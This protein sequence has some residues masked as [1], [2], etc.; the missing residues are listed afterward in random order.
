MKTICHKLL[1]VLLCIVN[2]IEN[3]FINI[4]LF[5]KFL[6]KQV[7]AY[8]KYKSFIDKL[9]HKFI[10]MIKNSE[11]GTIIK[12]NEFFGTYAPQLL[13]ESEYIGDST[14]IESNINEE[15]KYKDLMF[16]IGYGNLPPWYIFATNDIKFIT[17]MLNNVYYYGYRR[18]IKEIKKQKEIY[19]INNSFKNKKSRIACIFNKKNMFLLKHFVMLYNMYAFYSDKYTKESEDKGFVNI[20]KFK[21]FKADELELE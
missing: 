15:T 1:I 3:I 17:R 12:V 16:G 5:F 18:F 8:K 13:S 19:L 21:M 10:D 2:C 11:Q 6:P 4:F 14:K 9:T 7:K 20:S